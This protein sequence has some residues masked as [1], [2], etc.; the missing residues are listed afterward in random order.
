M[1]YTTAWAKVV[2]ENAILK[3]AIVLI[4]VTTSILG[5]SLVK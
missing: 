1:R 5:I 3:T 4:A 2:T